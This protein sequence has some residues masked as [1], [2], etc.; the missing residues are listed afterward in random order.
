MLGSALVAMLLGSGAAWLAVKTSRPWSVAFW[1]IAGMFALYLL[2]L[3]WNL[4]IVVMLRWLA[5]DYF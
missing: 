1:V 2:Y 3:A 4:L 5:R